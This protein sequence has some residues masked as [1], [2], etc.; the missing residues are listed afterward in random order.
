MMEGVSLMPPSF[1][2]Q[3]IM[4]STPTL[5]VGNTYEVHVRMYV[6]RCVC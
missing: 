6:V 5:R 4:G 2:L 1:L 3:T